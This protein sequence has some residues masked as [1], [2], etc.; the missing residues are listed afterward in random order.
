[1]VWWNKRQQPSHTQETPRC[2][3]A[4]TLFVLQAAVDDGYCTITHAVQAPTVSITVCQH[5]HTMPY[6]VALSSC[7]PLTSAV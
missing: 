5:R 2:G 7:C 6:Q 4:T 3:S 1:V